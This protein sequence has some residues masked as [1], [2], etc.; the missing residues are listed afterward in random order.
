MREV[1]VYRPVDLK[2]RLALWPFAGLSLTGLLQVHRGTSRLV[3]GKSVALRIACIAI[4]RE[5]LVAEEMVDHHTTRIAVVSTIGTVDVAKPSALAV[6]LNR[7][8]KDCT[9]LSIVHTSDAC[10]VALSVVGLHLIDD[11]GRKVLQDD[12]AVRAIELLTIDQELLHLLA[13]PC[14]GTIVVDHDAWEFL[15]KFL[16]ESPLLQLE[17]IGIIHHGIVDHRHLWQ[18]A[19]DHGL[20]HNLGILT[21]HDVLH[22]KVACATRQG[23]GELHFLEA[24]EGD[25]QDIVASL[26]IGQDELAAL[27][28]EGTS[29]LSAVRSEQAHLGAFEWVEALVFIN[30][31]SY[32]KSGD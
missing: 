20:S 13:V 26:D 29:H 1:G 32:I 27:L 14:I 16:H 6:L 23:K 4:S 19:F 12:I 11:L 17:G 8:V 18:F 10:E 28:H 31:T 2:Q 21:H 3:I 24:D 25:L 15:D 9:F 30:H 7:K 22:S 5:L